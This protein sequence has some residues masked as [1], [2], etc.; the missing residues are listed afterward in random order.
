MVTRLRCAYLRI[1]DLHFSQDRAL[2]L[3]ICF[4]NQGRYTFLFAEERKLVLTKI[5]HFIV[6]CVLVF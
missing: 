3:C 1:C 6:A 5:L 2:V 4:T